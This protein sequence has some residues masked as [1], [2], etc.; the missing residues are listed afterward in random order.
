[1]PKRK[2]AREGAARLSAD[3]RRE[4]LLDITKQLVVERGT[5]PITMG[6]VAERAGVT[7]ALLYKHFANK[8]ELLAALYRREAERLNRSMSGVV[9]AAPAGFEAKLRALVRSALEASEE[10]GLFFAPLR[11]FGTQPDVRTERRGWDRRTVKYFAQLAVDD[12]GIDERTAR[13]AVSLQLSGIQNLLSQLRS[14]PG[15][16]Q[17]AFL[18]HV[19][20]ESALGALLRLAHP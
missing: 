17:R 4:A 1:M 20:V 19:Y 14:R 2:A 12:F 3:G 18:E 7:R 11:T 5:A 15:A 6:T 8:D 9:T 10:H 16:E 13:A